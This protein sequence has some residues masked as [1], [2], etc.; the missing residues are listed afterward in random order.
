[1]I[2]L[3]MPSILGKLYTN[4][5][6]SDLMKKNSSTSWHNVGKWYNENVGE[7][8]HYY[9]QSVI[10]PNLL[11][12]LNFP[13]EKP[14]SLLDL[15]C[16][17][18]VISRHL[19][20]NVS[21]VGIDAAASL[22]KAARQ[23]SPR[24][25]DQFI[26]GDATSKLQIPHPPFTH[27]AIILAIQNIQSP[28]SV[29]QNAHRF[30]EENAPLIMILNHPCFRIPRQSSWGVDQEKKIQYRRIDRYM[31]S[32]EIP[33]QTHPGKG[34]SSPHTLSF[35]HP[36]STY[37]LWLKEAGFTIELIEEWCSDKV[38]QG[39]AAKMENRSRSEIPLFMAIKARK[40]H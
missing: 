18:G 30:L 32:M 31:S 24:D 5:F 9:H 19:P 20:P 7:E 14:S 6:K 37:S 1:M 2:N 33:I 15:A 21:Y 10:I 22:I 35:H 39:G 27:A 3:T 40:L 17:Q 12:L 13:K 36:L 34:K 4:K 11:K 26:Q 29:F 23:Y 16:G 8:G 38:S 25:T 28:L